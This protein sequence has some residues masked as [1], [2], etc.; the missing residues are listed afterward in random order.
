M[1]DSGAAYGLPVRWMDIL[2][3][4]E[5][6]ASVR[7]RVK[8]CALRYYIKLQIIRKVLDIICVSAVDV[9]KMSVRNIFPMLH[10]FR[11]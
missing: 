2:T 3:L 7:A 5:D 10:A 6:T 1:Q 4:Q 9:V 11:N 8:E